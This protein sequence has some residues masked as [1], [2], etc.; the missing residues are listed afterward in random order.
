[1]TIP[2][3]VGKVATS[4]IDALKVNPSCL[5]AILLAAI[6]AVLTF[7]ALQ[8]QVERDTARLAATMQL[9]QSCMSNAVPKRHDDIR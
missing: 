4:A 1:M 9:L 2:E 6:F 8:N 7:L 5:A 3:H